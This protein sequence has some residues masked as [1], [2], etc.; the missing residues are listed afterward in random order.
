MKS[1]IYYSKPQKVNQLN[2]PN[3]SRRGF[4]KL[5]LVFGKTSM[6]VNIHWMHWTTFAY[7][8][9]SNNISLHLASWSMIWSHTLKYIHRFC[10]RS[11]CG[12]E[13]G[14]W[15]GKK[16]ASPGCGISHFVTEVWEL[17]LEHCQVIKLHVPNGLLLRLEMGTNGGEDEVT[18]EFWATRSQRCSERVGRSKQQFPIVLTLFQGEIVN[19]F[20]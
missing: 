8:K 19:K 9:V 16:K 6:E 11:S 10:P 7:I 2:V 18:G 13:R 15:R 12:E 4:S 3:I 20:G 17:T 14:P 1:I 5:P